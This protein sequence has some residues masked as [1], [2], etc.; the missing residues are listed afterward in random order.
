MY[1]SARISQHHA[2]HHTPPMGGGCSI[3]FLMRACT[4]MVLW[5]RLLQAALCDIP[6]RRVFP[7]VGHLRRQ[8]D[9]D[10]A[11]P[12]HL[13]AALVGD[14]DGSSAAMMAPLLCDIPGVDEQA[15]ELL[16]GTCFVDHFLNFS[17]VP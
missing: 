1:Y 11:T 9:Y 15:E 7:L 4:P 6:G 5:P 8:A 16:C 13:A 12:L 2:S 10:G 14:Q 3:G 17:R